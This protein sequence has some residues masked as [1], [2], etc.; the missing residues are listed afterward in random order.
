MD[1]VYCSPCRIVHQG[2]HRF[3]RA[4]MIPRTTT[5]ACLLETGARAGDAT[6][7]RKR[8]RVCVVTPIANPE[9]PIVNP[10]AEHEDVSPR[11]R[12]AKS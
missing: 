8:E 1:M 2:G 11:G 6:A 12:D 10:S 4:L 3:K 7:G 9:H 5:C